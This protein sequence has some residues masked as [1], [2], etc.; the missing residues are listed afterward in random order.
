MLRR[1]NKD[2]IIGGVCGGIAEATD[3]SPLAWRILFLLVPSGL[4][5]Y[6]ILWALLKDED[7]E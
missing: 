7:D 2:S 3:T 5:A 6:I 1:S 4:W